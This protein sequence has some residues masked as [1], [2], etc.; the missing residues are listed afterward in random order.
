VYFLGENRWRGFDELPEPNGKIELF[1]GPD[2]SLAREP[3]GAGTVEY[4][5]DPLDPVPTTG[6]ATM[7]LGA[8]FAGPAEQ[9]AVEARDDVVVFTSEPLAEPLTVFGDM[10]AT[11][12]ASSSAVDTDFVVR[13]CR[14]TQDGRSIGLAD[15][16]V[17]ASWRDAC[18]GD[19]IFRAGVPRSPLTPG[20]V[21]EFTVS[22]WATACTFQPGDRLR[23]HVTSS[24]HPR[25]DRNLNTGGKALDSSDTVVA[26]QRVLWG[27]ATPSRITLGVLSQT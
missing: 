1:L 14:I 16:I 26:H 22:L 10:T 8:D 12:F 9:S 24:S 4:D 11:L 13:L 5:Y 17:R 6:G 7:H 27:T 25:W 20:K 21:E 19:G 15:G 23:V 18:A 2:G 3:G